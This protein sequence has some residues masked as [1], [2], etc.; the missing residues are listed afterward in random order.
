MI[1][2]AAACVKAGGIIAYPTEQCFG[3]GCDPKNSKAIDR[4][5]AI[6]NRSETVGLIIIGDTRAQ[7]DPY[8]DWRALSLKQQTRIIESW[9]GPRTWLIPASERCPPKLTGKHPTI[10]VRVPDYDVMKTL[11]AAAQTALVSTS[12]NLRAQPSLTTATQVREVFADQ[13]DY[14]IDLPVQ[15]LD[16]PSEIIDATTQDIIRPA[17]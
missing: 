17:P 10:A 15:G 3:L 7:L 9:P 6:K 13:I 16:H 1:R 2:Q 4:I 5:L 12:A 11:C 14:I 8:L